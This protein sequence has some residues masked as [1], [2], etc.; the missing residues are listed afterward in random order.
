MAV[1]VII[2]RT[3]PEGA[4]EHLKPLLQ[5]LRSR[6]MRQPGYI[7][8]ET[9]VNIDNPR[10]YLVLSSWQSVEDWNR[11]IADAQRAAVQKQVDA[12]LGRETLYQIYYHG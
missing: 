2:L 5:E 3:V 12:L 9:L 7:S 8:G 10:E 1:K 4:E 11:W 6:A